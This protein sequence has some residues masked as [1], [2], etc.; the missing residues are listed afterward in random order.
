[1][2]PKC[3]C[4]AGITIIFR[5]KTQEQLRLHSHCKHISAGCF[6][7]CLTKVGGIGG[8]YFWQLGFARKSPGFYVNDNGIIL[9]A[10]SFRCRLRT[11]EDDN[12]QSGLDRFLIVPLLLS[13]NYRNEPDPSI[14]PSSFSDIATA[15]ASLPRFQN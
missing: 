8:C 11:R 7:L 15:E 9:I 4:A 13:S 10:I 5:R 1:M 6:S 2:S 12:K 3:H 14:A